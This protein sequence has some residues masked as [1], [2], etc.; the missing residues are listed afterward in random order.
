MIDRQAKT[1]SLE[2]MEMFCALASSKTMEA[3]LPEDPPHD[4][5]KALAGDPVILAASDE[6][7]LRLRY[8]AM[9]DVLMTDRLDAARQTHSEE[10]K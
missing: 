9:R 6:Q 1:Y 2:D 4:A 5:L 3:V 7:E 10:G 8:K